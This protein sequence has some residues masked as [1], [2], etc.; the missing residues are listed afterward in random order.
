M[1]TLQK[2]HKVRESGIELLRILMMLQVIFLHVSDYGKY[3]D[4]GRNHLGTIDSAV[5][6]MLWLMSRCP[7]Y[8]YIVIF[9]YFSVTSNKTMG[10]IKSKILRTY[11]PMLFYSVTLP[12]LGAAIG[13]WELTPE[14]MISAFLPV[15][16]G[17]WYFMTLYLIVLILSPFI[18]RCLT[19]L[20][21]KEY[22]ILVLILFAMFSIWTM[23]EGIAPIDR[24]LNLNKIFLTD[25]GKGLYGFIYMYI[26]GGYLRLHIKSYD[27]AKLRF[28]V[29][30]VGLAVVNTA[31]VYFIPPYREVVAYND[32]PIS[33]IQGVC[34]V[35][36]FRD[37]KFK[38]KI[39]NYIAAFNLGVYM[40]HEQPFVREFIWDKVFP[41]TQHTAFYDVAIPIYLAKIALIC[42]IIYAVC[43]CIDQIRQ[44]IFKGIEHIASAAK[45]KRNTNYE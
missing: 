7:V 9:G 29:A 44:W 5:Y 31:L 35:L 19:N 33:V 23:L 30:F 27:K 13:L 10:S 3:T 24:V 17:T 34:L 43:A 37:L 8:V 22:T 42:V 41:M 6:W 40:I 18:N 26:L 25:D 4:M 16:S 39:I 32:N 36:F 11:L 12:F 14:Q 21:K 20:Q 28:L 38:S 45:E 15:L 2:T 1:N